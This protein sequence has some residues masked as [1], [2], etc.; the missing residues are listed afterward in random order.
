MP[1]IRRG[2]SYNFF[3]PFDSISDRQTYQYPI[4]KDEGHQ[5]I[6]TKYSYHQRLA[7]NNMK[8]SQELQLK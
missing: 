8:P 6:L 1:G 5:D 3:I 4:I 7:G 2:S